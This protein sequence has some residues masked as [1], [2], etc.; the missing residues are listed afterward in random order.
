MLTPE[1]TPPTA[2]TVLSLGTTRGGSG[3][4]TLARAGAAILD[5]IGAAIFVTTGVTRSITAPDLLTQHLRQVEGDRLLQ[6][7]ERAAG[8]FAVGPPPHELS[9]MPEASPL[10]V[11]VP[12]LHHAF[13][14]QRHEREILAGVPPAGLVLARGALEGRRPV[15]GVSLDLGHQRLQLLHQLATAGHREA[16]DH[17]DR[18]Q[19]AVVVVEPE[20]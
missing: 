5:S 1:A 6:L 12:D 7:V 10:H 18:G 8:R 19:R 11:V 16:P 3:S 9:R 14:P 4:G 13:G 20:E 17:T 2:R 15:P